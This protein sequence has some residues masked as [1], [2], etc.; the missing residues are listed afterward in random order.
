M[1]RTARVL[2]VLALALAP[3]ALVR[4]GDDDKSLVFDAAPAEWKAD[5]AKGGPMAP[6]LSFSLAAA[7]GETEAAKVTV[8]HLGAFAGSV[9]DNIKRWCGQFKG[10]DGEALDAAKVERQKLEIDGLKATLV[11]LAG[12]YNQPFGKPALKNARMIAVVVETDAGPHF[13][14][15]WGTEKTFAKHKDAFMKWLKSGKWTDASGKKADEKKPDAKKPD[16]KKPDEG[17]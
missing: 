15:F 8:H 12:T 13:V 16:E 4:A 1:T 14:K 2:A 9:E 7:E 5:E 11:E 10:A 6:K 3:A 17:K